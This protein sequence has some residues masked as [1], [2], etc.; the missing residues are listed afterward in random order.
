M[1]I[2]PDGGTT[3]FPK[4]GTLVDFMFRPGQT[5]VASGAVSAGA[6]V[7]NANV[8]TTISVSGS[9][10]WSSDISYAPYQS[11]LIDGLSTGGLVYG[12]IAVGLLSATSNPTAKVT[13]RMRNSGGSYDVILP[14]NTVSTNSTVRYVTYDLPNLQTSS[15]FNRIPF[16]FGIGVQSDSSVNTITARVMDNSWIAGQ[17][18][19]GTS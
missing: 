3:W 2:T 8:A 7:F 19:P 1:L 12:Q 17:F 13:M 9:T 15:N 5:P 18:V 14:L 16:A 6:R 4:E 11:G 10:V